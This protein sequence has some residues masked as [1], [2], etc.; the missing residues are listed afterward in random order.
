MRAASGG[1]AGV[2][3][4]ALSKEKMEEKKRKPP[5][6][7]KRQR[8]KRQPSGVE[9]EG[10]VKKKEKRGVMMSLRSTSSAQCHPDAWTR[11]LP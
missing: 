6:E 8:D 5:K 3:P 2:V 10:H 9:M 7:R 11:C 4:H 1:W